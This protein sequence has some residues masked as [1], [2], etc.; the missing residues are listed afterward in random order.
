MTAP[1]PPR[2]SSQDSP[3]DMSP[4]RLELPFPPALDPSTTAARAETAARLAGALAELGIQSLTLAD[5]RACTPMNLATRTA[6]LPK[7][8][9]EAAPGTTLSWREGSM[10]IDTDRIVVLAIAVHMSTIAEIHAEN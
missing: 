4:T 10:L 6:N 1:D 9:L 8:I 3:I 5:P 2:N 7:I